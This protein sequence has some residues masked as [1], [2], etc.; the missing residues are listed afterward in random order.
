[1]PF[2]ASG[3]VIGA[4]EHIERS[5]K[6]H[7]QT[8]DTL[9]FSFAVQERRSRSPP[10]ASA[11]LGRRARGVLAS[12]TGFGLLFGG[13][14]CGSWKALSQRGATRCAPARS[15]LQMLLLQRFFATQDIQLD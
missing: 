7:N 6:Y 1:M 13:G 8:K 14:R 3:F 5:K 11:T 9:S 4:Q 12:L 15:E 10:F 2:V